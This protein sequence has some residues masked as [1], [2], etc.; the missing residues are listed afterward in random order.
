MQPEE[1]RPKK[2]SE[3]EN[4]IEGRQELFFEMCIRSLTSNQRNSKNS[5]TSR[6]MG[7]FRYRN[8][9][10]QIRWQIIY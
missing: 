1:H 7:R 5:E 8:F 9:I 4:A 6:K 10:K 2:N 3:G